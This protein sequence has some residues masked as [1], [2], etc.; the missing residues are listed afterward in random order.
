[1][2]AKWFV[3]V[4]AYWDVWGVWGA[5][6]ETCGT[7]LKERNR[8]CIY[9]ACWNGVDCPDSNTDTD[10]CYERCCP[11]KSFL[12]CISFFIVLID[13][14]KLVNCNYLSFYKI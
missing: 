13:C 10:S 3:S 1:M 9:P 12:Y 8:E 2:N 11:G 5:C 7:G 4:P 14:M 6:S